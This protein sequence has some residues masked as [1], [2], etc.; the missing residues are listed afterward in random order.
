MRFP[1][2]RPSGASLRVRVALFALTAFVGSTALL[3]ASSGPVHPLP[4]AASHSVTLT[5]AT[6]N[7]QGSGSGFCGSVSGVV[8]GQTVHGVNLGPSFDNVYACGPTENTWWSSDPFEADFQCVELS[9][10]FMSVVY[11][12]QAAAGNGAVFVANNHQR[13]PSIPVGV[14]A[15]GSVPAPGDVVSL[16][17]GAANPNAEPAG[18]TAVV[19]DS[20]HVDM[21]TGNGYITLLEEN[22]GGVGT[23]V[24]NVSNWNES[25][26]NPSYANGLFWYTQISW[27]E[28]SGAHGP[29]GYMVDSAGH[30]YAYGGATSPVE[31]TVWPTQARATR[32]A[33]IPGTTSGYVLDSY[34]GIHAF[35]GAPRMRPSAYWFGQNASRDFVLTPTAK[36]GYVLDGEGGLHA[37]GTAPALASTVSWTWDIARA[38]V[39]RADGLGGWI[40]D[41]WGGM[42]GFGNAPGVRLNSPYYPGQDIVR[43]ACLRSDNDSGW[44]VDG[45]NDIH[46]FGGAPAVTSSIDFPGQD[47]A[48]A[49]NCAS[50]SGGYTLTSTGQVLPF[51]DAPAVLSTP[52]LINGQGSGLAVAK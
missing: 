35:G 20:S 30:V 25:M 3:T 32:M 50:D 48:R 31:Q 29:S 18:H 36:G 49:I 14:P 51:G 15:S 26:G 39:L 33:L 8:N 47:V 27:L 13:F 45:S 7:G 42:H 37:F 12:L 34:G 9:T 11:G 52:Q 40:L 24:I 43:A 19:S 5:A 22:D 44:W 10:R 38:V 2:P 28:L 23:G 46:S 16:S 41:G 21:S 6:P 4:V 1:Q 17:G